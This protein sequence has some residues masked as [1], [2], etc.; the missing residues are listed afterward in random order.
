MNNF[1]KPQSVKSCSNCLYG[2]KCP[3]EE[4]CEF[5][6]PLYTSE[7]IAKEYEEDLKMRVKFYEELAKEF[8]GNEY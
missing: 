7:S 4:I 5:Y 3:C 2:D 8:G 1:K 6:D